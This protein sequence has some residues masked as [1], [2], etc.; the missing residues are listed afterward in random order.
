VVTVQWARQ[1][2]VAVLLKTGYVQ[3]AEE[4]ERVLPDPVGREEVERWAAS[5]GITID[6]LISRMGGSP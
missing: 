1:E 4:A 5:H 3:A 6:D 2:I